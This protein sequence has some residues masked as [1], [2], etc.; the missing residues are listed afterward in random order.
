MRRTLTA[1]YIALLSLPAHAAEL[2]LRP[3]SRPQSYAISLRGSGMIAPEIQFIS[4]GRQPDNIPNINRVL[5]FNAVATADPTPALQVFVKAGL[6]SSRWSTNGSGDRY[7]NPGRLGW[8]VG[9]GLT[10]WPTRRWGLRIEIVR[11]RHQQS[12]VPKF[13][14]FTQT[15]A[16]VVWRLP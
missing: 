15:T 10:W 3:S 7:S 2:A 9:T 4:E 13:E 6:A 1:L 11:M 14:T 8:D 16:Q 12:D 5:M